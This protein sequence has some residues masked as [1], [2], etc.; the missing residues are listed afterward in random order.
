MLK[1]CSISCRFCLMCQISAWGGSSSHLLNRFRNHRVRKQTEMIEHVGENTVPMYLKMLWTPSGFLHRSTIIQEQSTT[2]CCRASRESAEREIHTSD[3]IL[4]N[5]CQ[6]K[7]ILIHP[8]ATNLYLIRP[9]PL[10][11]CT[12]EGAALHFSKEPRSSSGLRWRRSW[13]PL[14]VMC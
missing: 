11:F 13:R 14:A 6:L 4:I 12:A 1:S 9:L 3:V 7:F 5:S 8:H 10:F 2:K